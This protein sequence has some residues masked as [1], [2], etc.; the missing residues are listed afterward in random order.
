[1]ESFLLDDVSSVIRNKGIERIISP[2]IVQ[3]CHLL[4]SMERKEVENEVFA[5]LEMMAEEL[6]KACEDFVQVAK[7]LVGD[8]EEEWLKEEIEA[9][10]QSLTLFGRNITLVAQRLHLQPECQHHREELVTAAQ[11]ILVNTTKVLLLED[12]A[13]ARK[14]VRAAGWCLTCLDALE[15]AGDAA[16][17]RGPLADLAAALLR[18]GELA[19]HRPEERPGR[20]GSLLRSCVPPLIAAVRGHLRHPRDLQ[21]APSRRRVCALARKALGELLVRLDP[22]AAAPVAGSWNGALARRLRQLHQLLVAPEPKPLHLGLL[23]PPLAAVVW[24]CMRLAACSA[25]PERLHL[26][27]R[28]GRLLQLRSL[29]GIS[30]PPR[31]GQGRPEPGQERAAL[32]AATQALFQGFRTGLL[33]Q[34]LDTFTDTQSPLLRLFQVA[35]ATPADSAPYHDEALP[36][37]LQ[38][39]LATFHDRAKQML[40]VARLALVCCPRQEIGRDMEA[41]MAG[42]WGLVVRV[43]QLFSGSPQG[44]GRDWNPVTL[45]ALLRAWARESEHLLACFDDVLSIPEF[46]SVSIQEMT[47]HLDFFTWALE[48]GNSREFSRCVAYL[49][50]RATHIAQVMSR[51]VGRERDPI[52]RNGLRVLIQQLEQSSLVLR[53]AAERCSHEYGSP[54]TDAFLTMAKHLIYSAESLKEGLDG[55]NHPDIL[56]PLRD[57]VHSF[58]VAKRQLYFILPSLQSSA[59][60]ELKYQ[61]AP[62]LGENDPGTSYPP[63]DHSPHPLIPDPCPKRRGSPP[64]A[65]SKLFLAVENPDHQAVAS[66]CTNL[67]EHDAAVGAAQEA[68][69]GEGPLGPERMMGLQGISTLAPPI[70]D[71]AKEIAHCTTARTDRLLEVALQ[72]NGRT[73][74]TRQALAA[75][76][77]DWY[78][79]CQ[80]LFCHN[81]AADLPE[82]TAV[83][84]ELQRNLASLV[85]LAAKSGPMDLDKNSLDS[86]RHPEVLLQMQGRLKEA[87]THAKQL[88]DKVLA[89]DGLQAPKSWEESVEDGCLLWSVAVQDLLQYVEHL[90]GRKGLFL[91]PLRLAMKNQQGLQEGLD[92]AVDVSQRLQEAARLSSL[93]CG[94]EQKKGEVSFLRREVHVLTD[95]LLDVAQILASSPRPSPSLS[96]RF[97]LLCLEL[98][99]QVKALTGHLSIINADYECAFQD[100]I[101]PRPS[102]CK[103]PQ[104]RP[105]SSLE[106]MV[107]GIQAVQEIVVEGQEYGPCQEDLLMTLESILTL[108]KEVAQ[109]IPVLREYPEEWG[110]HILG[111][112]RWEWAAKAHHAVAELQAW[113]G[114]HTK[115]CRHLAQCLKP[116]EEPARAPEQDSI[117]PQVCEEDAAG[118]TAMGSVDSQS[119][120]PG[121]P[122]G[123]SVRTCIAGPAVPGTTTVDP[124]K[125]S[126]PQSPSP[127]CPATAAVPAE[128]NQPLPED[129]STDR[130]SRITRITR[131]MAKEVFLMARSLRRRG[132]VLTKDQLITSARKIATSGQDFAKLICIIAKNCID[133]R[134]S[135]ELLCVVERVQT[136]SNQLHI[137]SSVKASLA[138]S[139]SSEELLVENA[140]QLLQAVFKTMRA[141]EAASLRGLREPSP[142]PEELEV[143]AFCLQ[144][145]RKL[146]KHRLQETSNTA[147]D[148]LGL[149]NTSTKPPPTLA[150]LVHEAV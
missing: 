4:I 77:G 37:S 71:L 49:Q 15:A 75:M 133:Q 73:R 61:R 89:F 90:S 40:R 70:I 106:R 8:S 26:V 96:T 131:A 32:W 81:P 19:A 119:A 88:L 123:S 145:R 58:D 41:A 100:I 33:R 147:C 60:P 115:A 118:A 103:D 109:R 68:L 45:Q 46:L 93:L 92:Q 53:A 69:T 108:T 117:Q 86:T 127:R 7:R 149:R 23:D 12:A 47:K 36:K 144:W 51:C 13:M 1:M 18:L 124:S 64:P 113:K 2:M 80:Q 57:Q 76:A 30:G 72:L 67:L 82:S 137:I 85:Q 22:G 98:T 141:A 29:S 150:T 16:S 97:E 135:Q 25:P 3:L 34:I 83:F 6:A 28:C 24:H 27:A 48:S 50:G 65:I 142:D 84:L 138:R 38:L 78:P 130:D 79:L 63:T 94:D 59:A 52:F 140:Q 43:Q 56:S 101:F 95:A 62:G 55:T 110:M 99:L 5:S 91:L 146:L 105:E 143:A 42:I 126:S 104:T 66:A 54:D 112:L 114:G 128:L 120:A 74:E 121:T 10:A 17:L 39:F 136:M 35:V 129:G 11:Q 44:S 107:S 122:L 134:C 148:E 139:K 125:Q 132:C 9:A 111:W 116:G 87:E 102:V 14:M 21:L 20:A 31:R